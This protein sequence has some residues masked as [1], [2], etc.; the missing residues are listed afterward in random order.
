MQRVYDTH[1]YRTLRGLPANRSIY[2]FHLAS[3]RWRCKNTCIKSKIH[4]NRVEGKIIQKSANRRK[5]RKDEML[6]TDIFMQIFEHGISSRTLTPTLY[7]RRSLWVEQYVA[8]L[9]K[10]LQY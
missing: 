10:V 5:C 4:V 9:V 3:F 7:K 8:G 1:N 6:K 2:R